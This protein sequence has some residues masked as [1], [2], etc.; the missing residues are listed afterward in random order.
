M[1]QMQQMYREAFERGERDFE[2]GLKR[3][4]NPFKTDN[5]TYMAREWLAGYNNASDAYK[6]L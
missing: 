1:D 4:D 6:A 2:R 3:S 5:A